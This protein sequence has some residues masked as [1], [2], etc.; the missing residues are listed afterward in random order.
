MTSSPAGLIF[1]VIFAMAVGY[2]LELRAERRAEPSP[3]AR[4]I[5]EATAELEL[6]GY[7]R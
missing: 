6:R 1:G 4:A 2:V 3:L 5:E 7:P